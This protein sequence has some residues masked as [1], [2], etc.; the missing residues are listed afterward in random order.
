M[1]SISPNNG[2]GRSL[3]APRLGWEPR[4]SRRPF[5][6]HGMQRCGAAPPSPIRRRKTSPT[7]QKVSGCVPSR[8]T[9]FHLHPCPLWA[10]SLPA[11]CPLRARSLPVP[12]RRLVERGTLSNVSGSDVF[13]LGKPLNPSRCHKNSLV[14]LQGWITPNYPNY[15]RDI[16]A[17]TCITKQRD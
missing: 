2:F 4:K 6:G 5:L 7:N 15:R 9:Y 12:S 11:A 13:P 10:R 14:V 16:E 1:A 17:Y 8:Q 3:S